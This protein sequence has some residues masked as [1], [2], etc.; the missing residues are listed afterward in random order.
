MGRNFEYDLVVIGSGPG[1]QKAAIQAAKLGK[2]VAIVDVN[3]LVGGVCLHDGTIPSKSFREAI[4]HLSGYKE[5][6]HYGRAYRVKHD[7]KIEDLTKRCDGIVGECEQTVRAQLLRNRVEIVHGFGSLH[8]ANTVR[9][10]NANRHGLSSSEFF[11]P[12]Q[13]IAWAAIASSRPTGPTF[14]PVFAFT[15]TRSA[16]TSSNSARRRR[17]AGL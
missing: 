17:M 10:V 8:D 13:T 11:L 5:R 14:S 6:S 3:S 9:V 12:M 4:V 7:V 1:G 15:F 16:S 2:K